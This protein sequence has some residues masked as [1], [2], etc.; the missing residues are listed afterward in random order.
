MKALKKKIISGK[1][2]PI[3]FFTGPESYLKEEIA[4]MIRAMIFPSQADATLNTTTLYGGDLTLGELASKASEYPMFTE[5]QLL[6]VKEFEK[7]RRTGSREQQAFHEEKFCAYVKKPAAFTILVLDTDC[8]DRKELDK[9]PFRNL[10]SCRTDFP[11]IH[12]TDLFATERAKASG[13][14]FEPEALKLFTAC[15]EQ[16]AREIAQETD[17]LIL[18]AS[19]KRKEKTITAQDICDCVGISKTYN[20]FELEK[21]LAA[22]NLR[23]SSGISLMIMD[24]EGYREG[25]GRIVRYLTTFFMRLWKL[26]SPGIAALPPSDIAR[27]L[28]MYGKQEFFVKNYINYAKTFSPEEI[29]SAIER[30]R[31]TDAALK[32]LRPYPDERFLLLELMRKILDQTAEPVQSRYSLTS[33]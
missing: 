14:E 26:S 20:V 5:K 24:R 28:G 21:A 9:T 13:W 7:V 16:S 25:L 32:G 8:N 15:I 10:Q 3:Y 22:R 2:E 30:L 12:N 23:L 17:K 19:S 11:G 29:R 18:Y 4:G 31:E 33:S 1:I 27:T 6:I